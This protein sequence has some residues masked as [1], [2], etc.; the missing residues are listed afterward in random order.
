MTGKPPSRNRAVF[1]DRDGTL[2]EDRGYLSRWED[3]KVFPDVSELNLLKSQGF[4]LIGIT[5]Q[6]GIARGIVSEDFVRQVNNVFI[7]RYGFDGFYYCPHHPDEGCSCRKPGPGM[8]LKARDEHGLDLQ[9]SY[10]IGD[11]EADMLLARAIGAT[12]VLVLTGEARE[13]EN[14][15][16]R[17]RDLKE[18]VRF[19][20]DN[21]KRA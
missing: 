7:E 20:L 5:N 3:F 21:E 13:S 15:R 10:V 8:A 14:A 18:A 16:F 6:S 19:I 2:C 9:A 12:A 17:A 1:L 11:K 4:K